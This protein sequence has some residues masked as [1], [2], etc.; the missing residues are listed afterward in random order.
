MRVSIAFDESM[1]MFAK[2]DDSAVLDLVAHFLGMA[3]HHNVNSAPSAI[4]AL[5]VISRAGP[6]PV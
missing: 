4:T 2:D 1:V 5:E 6:V 3:T